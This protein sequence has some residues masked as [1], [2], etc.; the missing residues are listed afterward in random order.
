MQSSL[1]V[2]LSAQLTLQKRLES[3]ANNVAN[4]ST[5]GFRAEEIRFETLLSETPLDPVSFVSSGDTYL[6][7][8]AGE[9]AKTDN[10]LDVAVQG[11]A[12]LAIQTPAGTVYTRDGRMRI[13]EAGQLE[14][15]GG[16]P[17]LD[18][19]GAPILIEAAA[20][21]P[22]IGRDGM[23]TQ[24]GRQMGAVGLFR[25]DERAHLTR[26]E[27]SGVMP[28][29]PAVPA[30]DFTNVGLLQGYVERS[31]VNPVMEMSRLIM[32][33]RALEAVTASIN[34][35]ESSLEDAV[36]TLGSTTG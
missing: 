18:A 21:P 11:E 15:L 31:N 5:A 14:T 28:D 4:S 7:R 27:N 32:V 25:I 35:A 24:N 30:L 8:R 19:G 26:Y 33:T 6:S 20:G 1:Y 16:H 36:Q 34:T 9:I 2:A 22:Q 23:I 3:I 12:W 29:Q 10:P 13:S 17:V